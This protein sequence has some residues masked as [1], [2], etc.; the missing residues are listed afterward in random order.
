MDAAAV[1]K[2]EFSHT[3]RFTSSSMNDDG[4]S[5]F[6]IYCADGN[7]FA[8]RKYSTGF[9]RGAALVSFHKANFVYRIM[10]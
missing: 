6:Y 4:S 2:K 3:V 9:H 1:G 8:L 5:L 10:C 7:S